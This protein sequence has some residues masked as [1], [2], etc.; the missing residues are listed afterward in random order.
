MY[1]GQFAETRY[2]ANNT[3][4]SAQVVV[5]QNQLLAW[6]AAWSSGDY[7]RATQIRALMSDNLGKV[8]DKLAVLPGE[9]QL[10]YARVAIIIA[11]ALFLYGIAAVSRRI[12]IKLGALFLGIAVYAFAVVALVLA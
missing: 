11:T 3:K 8:V 7:S 2:V 9:A 6:Q 12:T 10:P 4:R 1:L 5:D